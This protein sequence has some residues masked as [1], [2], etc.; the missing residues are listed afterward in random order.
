MQDM[1]VKPQLMEVRKEKAKSRQ[2]TIHR[3]FLVDH[4]SQY[5]FMKVPLHSRFCSICISTL[6]W[7]Q[8]SIFIC[9][10]NGLCLCH[11]LVRFAIWTNTFCSP[12]VYFHSH[13]GANICAVFLPLCSTHLLSSLTSSALLSAHFCPSAT[14]SILLFCPVCFSLFPI[15]LHP[16]F[17]LFCLPSSICLSLTFFSFLDL[18]CQL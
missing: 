11:C 18:L 8:V 15:C 13:L 7:C 12:P 4:L 3:I 6:N 1:Q 10:F 5:H 16:S 17:L 2:F 14:F 9:A